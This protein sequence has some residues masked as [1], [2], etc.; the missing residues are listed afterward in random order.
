MYRP[1]LESAAEHLQALAEKGPLPAHDGQP[2][3][4]L[5]V[6]PGGMVLFADGLRFD[7]SHRLASRVRDKGW[8]VTLSMRWAG[9]PTVTATAKPAVSP[10][11]KDITGVSLGEDFSPSDSCRRAAVDDG[12]LPQTAGLKRLPVPRCG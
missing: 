12:P 7:V 8:T 2:L 4:E 10:V 9:L 11:S 1:W 5:L 3:E 6:E